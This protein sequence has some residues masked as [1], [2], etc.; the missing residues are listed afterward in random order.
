MRGLKPELRAAVGSQVPETME[1]AYL[2]A[3]VQQEIQED[4]RGKGHRAPYQAR[5]DIGKVEAPKPGFK[6][7]TGDLWKDR[8][9]REYHRANHLCFKCGDM[10]DLTH[11]CGQKQV[12]VAN[13][14]EQ[15]EDPI[16]LSDEVLNIM[17]M[18]DLAEAQLL[19]LSLNAM[20]RPEDSHCLRLMALVGNQVMLILVDSGSRAALSTQIC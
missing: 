17:E 7:A 19:S 11:Q 3:R 20:A 5:A 4:S 14:L 13:V 1:R 2:L 18:H 10:F 9:L 15:S 16:L 8:Q 6:A 12:A